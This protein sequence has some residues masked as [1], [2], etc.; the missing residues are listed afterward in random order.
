[1]TSGVG[2]KKW[3]ERAQI[4]QV[5]QQDRKPSLHLN[6][7][8]MKFDAGMPNHIFRPMGENIHLEEMARDE[9]GCAKPAEAFVVEGL[10]ATEGCLKTVN[11]DIN[12][13]YNKVS[14]I[15]VNICVWLDLKLLVADFQRR[16]IVLQKHAL[17]KFMAM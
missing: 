4:G 6:H 10:S 13:Q 12:M 3:E 8:N 14:Q 11:T 9:F 17:L 1:M 2:I 16:V 5:K 7:F 15:T